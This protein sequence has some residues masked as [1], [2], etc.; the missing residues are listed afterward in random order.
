MPVT[1]FSLVSRL[2]APP[3]QGR[4]MTEDRSKNIRCS[5]MAIR[6]TNSILLLPFTDPKADAYIINYRELV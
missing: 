3:R 5:A 2:E 1:L 4:P 6:I